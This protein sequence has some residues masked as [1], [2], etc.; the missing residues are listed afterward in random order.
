MAEIDLAP[1]PI[2]LAWNLQGDPARSSFVAAAESAFGLALPL[3]SNTTTQSDRGTLMWIGPKSW[4]WILHEGAANGEAFESRRDAMNAHGGALFDVSAARVAFIV[5]GPLAARVIAKHCPLD[6][7]PR[8]FGAGSCAQSV[9]AGI[10]ALLY[11]RD[12]AP[13]FV[14]MVA[15]SFAR[16]V[17]HAL[18]VSAASYGFESA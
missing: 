13:T 15:R 4:V 2:V 3:R 18:S 16:D 1:T 6:L 7:H 9:F 17:W 5:K 11:K 14:L 12:D 8:V 10:N